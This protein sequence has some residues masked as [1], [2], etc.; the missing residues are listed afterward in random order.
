MS[1]FNKCVSR[2]VV[3]LV[4]V[5]LVSVIIFLP[6]AFKFASN[7]IIDKISSRMY[8][9]RDI[10]NNDMEVCWDLLILLVLS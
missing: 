7:R 5:F 8:L 3:V 4:P 10:M 6:I 9:R 1:P 2:H